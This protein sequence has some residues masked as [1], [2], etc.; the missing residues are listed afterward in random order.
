MSKALTK[1]TIFCTEDEVK[2]ARKRLRASVKRI[3]TIDFVRGLKQALTLFLGE[4][5]EFEINRNK[6]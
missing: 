1:Q 3:G 5:D 2:K 4:L 6:H